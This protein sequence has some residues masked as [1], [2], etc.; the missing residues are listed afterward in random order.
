MVQGTQ[1][2]T[3]NGV[4]SGTAGLTMNGTAKLTLGGANTYNS[5]TT[6]NSGTVLVNGSLVSAVNVGA[7]STLGGIG[8]IS[9]DINNSGTLAPGVGVG[10]LSATGN[11]TD[12]ASAI[13]NID[14]SGA[15]ADMLAVTGNIDLS[16]LDNLNVT[17]SGTGS[18]WII[19]TYTGTLSGTFDSVTSG[20]SVDYGTGSNSQITLHTPGSG[21]IQSAVPEP[22]TIGLGLFA[23]ALA[24]VFRRR[25]HGDR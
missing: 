2:L 23:F 6:V 7:G 9:N 19:A 13:W 8:T 17:G 22:G 11:V 4:I 15:S 20:Y 25:N 3:L 12:G 21:T 1:D 24:T 5:A 10:T 18:S 14:L 16:A